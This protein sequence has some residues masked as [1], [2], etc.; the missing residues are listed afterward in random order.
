MAENIVSKSKRATVQF[1]NGV[2]VDGY[3]MPD[4]T[5]RVGI[6]T[7]SLVAGYAEN[8]LRKELTGTRSKALQSQGSSAR[9]SRSGTRS[10]ALQSIG[11]SGEIQKDT[12]VTLTGEREERTISTKDF[13]R[14]LRHADRAGKA[15]AGAIL[16]ALEDLALNDFFRDA[17]G[18]RP[19][20][21]EE[22]RARFYTAYAATINWLL[23]DKAEALA[24][25]AWR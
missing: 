4:G 20:S 11:F 15:E 21:I 25:I 1:C 24:L 7:A 23:E 14:F 10:E 3:E 9:T 18:H 6:T 19:L 12:R 17:F 22:K 5:F 8:Y 16:N 13:L 2:S